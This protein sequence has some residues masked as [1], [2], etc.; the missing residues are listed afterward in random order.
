MI[1]YELKLTLDIAY[2]FSKLLANYLKCCIESFTELMVRISWTYTKLVLCNLVEQ[3][4]KNGC[5]NGISHNK[6]KCKTPFRLTDPMKICKSI[7]NLIYYFTK[8]ET[9]KELIKH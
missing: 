5:S 7:F 8:R 3:K 1:G 9:L 4:G 2:S 6:I